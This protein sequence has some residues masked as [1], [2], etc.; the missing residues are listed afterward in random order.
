MVTTLALKGLLCHDVLVY[1]HTVVLLGCFVK[2]GEAQRLRHLLRLRRGYQL[3][4]PRP[5]A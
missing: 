5:E 4:L 2:G 3:H 1:A